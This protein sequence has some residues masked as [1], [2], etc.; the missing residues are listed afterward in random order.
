LLN[1]VVDEPHG[2]AGAY[3]ILKA[4]GFERLLAHSLALR[5]FGAG[6]QYVGQNHAQFGHIDRVSEMRVGPA[7]NACF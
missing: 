6:A 2:R 3:K 1:G 4:A 7:A 5:V